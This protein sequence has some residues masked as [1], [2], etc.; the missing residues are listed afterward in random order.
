MVLTRYVESWGL[1][2][3]VV[4]TDYQALD[5]LRQEASDF[6]MV[7]LDIHKTR[8]EGL[9]LATEIRSF[10]HNDHLPLILIISL[11]LW[12]EASRS[13]ELVFAASITRPVKPAPL[14]DSLFSLF[15]DQPVRVKQPASR[16]GFDA[17][18]GR[19]HPLRILLAEDTFANQKMFQYSLESMGYGVDIV[20]N[21]L[22]VLDAVE[23][24]LYDLVLMDVQMPEMDGIDATQHL[25]SNQPE[26]NQPWI[27]ALTAHAMEGDRERCLAAGMDDYVSKPVHVEELAEA[28]RRV[29]PSKTLVPEESPVEKDQAEGDKAASAPERTITEIAEYVP[30]A[31]VLQQQTIVE[32]HPP[33]PP[34]DAERSHHFLSTIK[35]GGAEL[36]RDFINTFLTD[37]AERL[38]T[39]QTAQA[40]EALPKMQQAAHS[41]K[42]LS[43]QVGAVILSKLSEQLE[44]K[45]ID[46]TL[47]GTQELVHRTTVEYDRVEAALLEEM[48]RIA[49]E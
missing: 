6:D 14:Y 22:E 13:E 37:M 4:T 9:D 42:S 48:R 31:G 24:T 2:P 27:I 44:L 12:Y 25:R 36:A 34:L 20:K 21:G 1:I 30:A 26:E 16:G 47:E 38:A 40:E 17:G 18:L 19:R 28:L 33:A 41:L 46:N 10:P 39:I 32:H 49:E 45:G 35:K 43:G 11:R 15:T 5:R 29:P 7:I 3:E 8:M 23:H